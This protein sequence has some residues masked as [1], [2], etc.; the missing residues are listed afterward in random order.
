MELKDKDIE[1][2]ISKVQPKLAASLSQISPHHKED[3]E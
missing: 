3:L 1:F 2:I